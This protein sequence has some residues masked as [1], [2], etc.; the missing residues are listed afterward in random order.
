VVCFLVPDV[1]P[2]VPSLAGVGEAAEPVVELAQSAVEAAVD[3]SSAGTASAYPR[4]AFL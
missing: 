2:D 3:A 4:L 1:V